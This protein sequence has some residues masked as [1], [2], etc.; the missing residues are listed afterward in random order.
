MTTRI[1]LDLSFAGKTPLVTSNKR[2]TLINIQRLLRGINAGSQYRLGSTAPIVKTTPTIVPASATVTFTQA[3]PVT[4]GQTVTIAGTAMTAQQSRARTTLTCVSAIAGN[5]VVL[6]GVTFTAAA[7][8][9]TLGEATFSIDTS[10]TATAT[11]L[12]AQIN[13]Y[14]SPK[15]S[16][17]VTCPFT[18]AGVVTVCAVAEGTS[19]NAITLTTTG[20]TITAA[21]ATL[22]NGAAIANNKFDFGSGTTNVAASFTRA[23]NASTTAAINQVT[24]AITSAGVVT[25]TSVVGGVAGNAVTLTSSSGTTL[26][27]TGSGFLA[28]GSQGA[29]TTLTF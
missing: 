4:V 17:L 21:N 10:D 9:V 24:A 20:G 16:G 27:V 13:A 23:V 8:A 26:A 12:A 15:I 19:G 1:L 25:L 2:Q 5:T 18:A 14:G 28:S 11:S 29:T 3:N 7:G 22:V 6:N